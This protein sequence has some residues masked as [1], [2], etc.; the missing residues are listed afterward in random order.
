[1]RSFRVILRSNENQIYTVVQAL[2]ESKAEKLARSKAPKGYR[3]V[4][5]QAL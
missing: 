5:I 4:R 3:V 1:M 2:E